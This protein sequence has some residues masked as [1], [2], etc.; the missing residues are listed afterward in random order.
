VIS[1]LEG[2][3][4]LYSVNFG[5]TAAA[6]SLG[7]LPA[8]STFREAVFFFFTFRTDTLAFETECLAFVDTFF[9]DVDGLLAGF[10]P[11]NSLLLLPR[12]WPDAHIE[13]S[14]RKTPKL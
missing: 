3:A 10:V 2:R 9:A 7:G 6:A 13:S 8:F 5:F 14:I 1:T 11:P 12:S 4:G